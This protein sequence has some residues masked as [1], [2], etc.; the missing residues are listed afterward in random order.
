[1]CM[2]F[3]HAVRACMTGCEHAK[4]SLAMYVL[5]KKFII[6]TNHKPLVLETKVSTAFLQ[7]FKLSPEIDTLRV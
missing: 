6:E 2:L 3:V 5:G 4:N 7:E 1:M